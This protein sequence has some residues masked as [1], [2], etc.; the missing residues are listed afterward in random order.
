MPTKYKNIQGHFNFEQVYLDQ[1]NKVNNEEANFLEIGCY[2]GK[3]TIFLAEY[4]KESN[5][6]ITLHVIDTFN[7]EG[8]SDRLTDFYNRFV[9]NINACNVSDVIKVYSGTSD[10]FVTEFK[11]DFFDFVYI[12]GLHTY[13]QVSSDIKNYLPKVKSGC[14]LAGHDYQYAPVRQAVDELLQDLTFY[15]NT[16]IY[17]K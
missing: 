15:R 8:N 16:W 17:T 1:V 10:S 9:D 2:L 4:I 12:D 3:S 11:N 13:D 6:K 7:G 14:T 5:K